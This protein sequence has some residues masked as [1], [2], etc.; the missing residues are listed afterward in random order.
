MRSFHS[1]LSLAPFIRSNCLFL[2][3]SFHFLL[4]FFHSN[5]LVC[6]LLFWCDFFFFILILLHTHT[7]TLPL[8]V[9]AAFFCSIL[10]TKI[11]INGH[12][13]IL[14]ASE[15][16]CIL[17][18]FPSNSWVPCANTLS[19]LDGS[20]N[21]INP[22]PLQI[23]KAKRSRRKNWLVDFGTFQCYVSFCLL[24]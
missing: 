11:Y 22:K 13:C 1:L 5:F 21:V 24:L 6:L 17:T 12:K 4:V 15:H 2:M 10:F 20:P 16:V 3:L 19:T 18:F 8:S 9:S 14:Y 23:N 7:H